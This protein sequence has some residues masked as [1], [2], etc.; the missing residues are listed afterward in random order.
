MTYTKCAAC[1]AYHGH[2]FECPEIT[3]D[4]AKKQLLVYHSQWL[5]AQNKYSKK[6]A[7]WIGQL[8]FW[9]GKFHALRHENNKLRAALK[10]AIPAAVEPPS[11]PAPT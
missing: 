2:S 11:P 9:Q 4:E 8:Q 5:E 10:R 6:R 7:G 3:L 1:G